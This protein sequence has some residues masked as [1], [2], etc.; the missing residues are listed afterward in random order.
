M[1]G[2]L[3]K[4]LSINQAGV[5]RREFLQTTLAAGAALTIPDLFAQ[6]AGASPGVSPGC[7]PTAGGKTVA[8]NRPPTGDWC[9]TS[10]AERP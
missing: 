10:L 7:S 9:F 2:W 4:I 3:F 5:N 8:R 6:T 1:L